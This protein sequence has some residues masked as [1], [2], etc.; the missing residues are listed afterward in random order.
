MRNWGF[1]HNI[2]QTSHKKAKS[3]KHIGYMMDVAN[4]SFQTCGPKKKNMHYKY[5]NL[6]SSSSHIIVASLVTLGDVKMNVP[7]RTG[8]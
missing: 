3:M 5:K 8:L 1:N 7:D 4:R 6:F 2:T